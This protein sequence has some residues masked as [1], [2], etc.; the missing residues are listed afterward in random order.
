MIR[1]NKIRLLQRLSVR[2]VCLLLA[3]S[4][5]VGM[6]G[7][8]NKTGNPTET[9]DST[10]NIG[11]TEETES[12]EPTETETEPAY[13][14][15]GTKRAWVNSGDVRLNVRS[16]PNKDSTLMAS[17]ADRQEIKILDETPVDGYYKISGK[18]YKTGKI[19]EG[20]GHS[21]YIS[22]EAPEPPQVKL[23]IP[24][25]QQTD[26]KWGD[27]LLGSTKKTMYDI[28]CATCSLA[29]S[30]TFLKGKTVL[31]DE[32]A[33]RSHYTA[34]GEIAWPKD[35]Y[36]NYNKYNYLQ[37]VYNK[38][39]EG[40][41]VLIGRTRA[42]GSPHW[43]LI[44]GY[45][46]DGI[47]LKAEDFLINDP[48]PYGRTNLKQYTDEYPKFKKMIYYCKDRSLVEGSEE[49][50]AASE[51]AAAAEAEAASKA[52]AEAEAASKAAAE[53]EAASKAAAEAEAASK[54]AVQSESSDQ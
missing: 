12:T 16:E 5:C 2:M 21:D 39:H 28:G 29:M 19:M 22:F 27:M 31:P 9:D 4:M 6:T 49:S 23:D 54:T 14:E 24:L 36:W 47:E 51:A 13:N 42:N 53:A 44:T 1:Q 8:S 17:F 37:F 50:I 26:E 52:A 41:P 11:G 25:Y 35:Y 7:C 33:E 10:A 40:I 3:G 15:D 32:L 43:V 46:G 45:V 20:Y 30:E 38:L 18:D 48:L 34:S